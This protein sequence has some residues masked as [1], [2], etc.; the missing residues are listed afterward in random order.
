MGADSGDRSGVL[1]CVLVQSYIL[2][3]INT[4]FGD[5][6]NTIKVEGNTSCVYILHAII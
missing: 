2:V 4:E 3:A 6:A 1:Q 5:M